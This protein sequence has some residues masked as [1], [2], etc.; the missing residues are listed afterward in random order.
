MRLVFNPSRDNAVVYGKAGQ[1]VAPGEWAYVDDGAYPKVQKFLNDRLLVDVAIPDKVPSNV[2][3]G[4]AEAIRQA[5]ADRARLA[6]SIKDQQ[7]NR[8]KVGAANDKEGA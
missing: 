5:V 4:A 1:M 8:R 7:Q 2:T 3:P 6:A